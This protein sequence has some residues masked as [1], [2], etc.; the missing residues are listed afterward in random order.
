[1]DINVNVA[2]VFKLPSGN[3]KVSATATAQYE[4]RG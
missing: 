1:M 4:K 2:E 3:L